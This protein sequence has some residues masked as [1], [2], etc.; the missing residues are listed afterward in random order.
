MLL[1]IFIWPNFF[2]A[3][4]PHFEVK[5]QFTFLQKS[6][7]WFSLDQHILDKK[8]RVYSRGKGNTTCNQ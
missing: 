3:Y 6:C 5:V 2:L 8:N 4:D 1:Q 7:I